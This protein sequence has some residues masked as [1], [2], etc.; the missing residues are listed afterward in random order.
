MKMIGCYCNYSKRG[1]L[2]LWPTT[3][4]MA[5]N[6]NNNNNINNN[7]NSSSS[8]NKLLHGWETV[9]DTFLTTHMVRFLQ[10]LFSFYLIF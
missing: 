2:L 5:L 7:S 3:A 10:N 4:G 1:T 9:Q 6:N 8:K